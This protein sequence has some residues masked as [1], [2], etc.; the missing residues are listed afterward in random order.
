MKISE[1]SVARLESWFA[2]QGWQPFDF[3]KEV[4]QAMAKGESGLLHAPTGM[5]K[6]LAVWLGG[7]SYLSKQLSDK[8]LQILWLTPLRALAG[9]TCKALE[10]PLAELAPEVYVQARTGDTS[11][12]AKQKQEKKLP[13][14]L[15]TTPE[16]LTL[17]LSRPTAGKMMSSLQVVIVDEWHELLGSK[18]GV[19]TELALARLHRFV[20]SLLVWG[21]SATLGNLQE[22]MLHLLGYQED[23]IPRP[24][25]LVQGSINKELIIDALLPDS[26]ERFPWAG[27]LGLKMLPQVLAELAEVNTALV[28]TNTRSQCELWY[29]AIVEARPEWAVGLHHGSLASDERQA[30][31]AG[32]KAGEIKIV[33][34][35]SSLDL[36]VDFSPVER[37]LQVGSPKGVARLLQRAGR[38]GH[39]PSKA[40]RV[41]CVPASAF[42]LIEAAAARDAAGSRSLEGRAPYCCPLD[43]LAQHA[44]SL[45]LGG[46][47]QADELFREVRCSP[48]YHD[49]SL[50]EWEWLLDFLCRGG[51]TLSA[52][53]EYHK[54]SEEKGVYT[55]SD[56]TIAK[57]HRMS[58]GTIV[59]DAAIQVRYM[60]GARLGSV[61]ESFIS[62]LRPGDTFL[63]AGRALELVRLHNLTAYVRAAAKSGAVPIW[64]GGRMPLSSQLAEAVCTRLDKAAQGVYEGVE[65][66]SVKPI[67]ELQLAWS[68]IPRS[69]Q[70]LLE[71]VTSREGYH[72]FLYPFAGRLVHEGLA[73]LLA[74]RLSRFEPLTFSWA[75]NDYGL[76][77]LSRKNPPVESALAGPLFA[78]ENLTED[79]VESQNAAE[80]AK[81]RFREIARI[82]GLVFEGY[83][84][85]GKTARQI[86]ATSSLIFDVFKRYDPEHPLLQQAENEVLDRQLERSRLYATLEQLQNRQLLKTEPQR[87]TPLA[88]PLLVDR[89]RE[90]L[91][92]ENLRERLQRLLSS[93]EKQA[94]KTVKAAK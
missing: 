93:L 30:V 27:H 62:R 65:M 14:A 13:P 68:A 9:D 64:Y 60:K 53:P 22:A 50:P 85:K 59:S 63:F 83:P 84:G 17:L 2:K 42:E 54:L 19:Q 43:V 92:S 52:Y 49:L 11:S 34:C 36:G 29:Q 76:E 8:G 74:Y 23:S 10:E 32:L 72:I 44:V 48:S 79:I 45:A 26:T 94:D 89:L 88:F 28:F 1:L 69:D 82:A 77:L 73:A 6:T 55:V 87:I 66:L 41:T 58:I 35:T 25:R 4:W 61:E 51:S 33:V 38:S 18:R 12:Y 57:R 86:Q 40:S 21:L 39:S 5:G 24:G 56:A 81:N 16:S 75:V 71:R 31:E 3:Q 37:V 46:G 7:L 78:T 70:V 20:P 90:K 80:L 91:T 67:L 47:F 15:V